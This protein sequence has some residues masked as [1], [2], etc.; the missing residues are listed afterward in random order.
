MRF[1]VLLIAALALSCSPE[2]PP[3]NLA[4]ALER[5]RAEHQLVLLDFYRDT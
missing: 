4:E 5:A 3:R 1:A 2:A